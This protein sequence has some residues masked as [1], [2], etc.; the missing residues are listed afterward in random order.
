MS[1]S[2]LTSML[3]YILSIALGVA[4]FYIVSDWAKEQKIKQAGEAVS[5]IINFVLFIWLSKIILSLPLLFRDPLALL[6]YP[7]NSKA[8]YLA[9]LFSAAVL[10][11][12]VNSGQVKGQAIFGTLLHIL[13]PAAFFYEFAQLAWFGNAYAFGNL[14]LYAV[15]LGLFFGVNDRLSLYALST[16]LLSLWAGGMLLNAV[17]ELFPSIFGY[18]MEPWFILLFF[19]A[20]QFLIFLNKRRRSTNE[21]Y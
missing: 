12:G 8:F 2:A 19:T 13:L 3:I 20:S 6:A 14:I 1:S 4:V 11:Y 17:L 16:V 18:A 5:Q 9:I 7:S 10:L 15:L 21:C